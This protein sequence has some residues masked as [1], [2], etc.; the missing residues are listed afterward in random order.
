M[1]STVRREPE[2]WVWIPGCRTIRVRSVQ[3]AARPTVGRVPEDAELALR[4]AEWLAVQ[5]GVSGTRYAEALRVAG[6]VDAAVEVCREVAELGY[7]TGY[8]E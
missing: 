4:R 3:A 8:S 2:S 1:S 6:Q 7:F 5:D